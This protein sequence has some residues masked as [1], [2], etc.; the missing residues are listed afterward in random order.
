MGTPTRRSHGARVCGNLQFSVGVRPLSDVTVRRFTSLHLLDRLAGTALSVF[1]LALAVARLTKVAAVE[2]LVIDLLQRKPAASG[3]LG[4][5]YI[6]AVKIAAIR[7]IRMK[8][9]ERL[10]APIA[11][12]PPSVR[13]F[14]AFY[15]TDSSLR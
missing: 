9:L 3:V 6:R 1:D 13:T 15:Q 2:Q 14:L 11:S 5:C 12:K 4:L 7:R 8:V 10:N